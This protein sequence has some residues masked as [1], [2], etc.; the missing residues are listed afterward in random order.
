[1]NLI[2]WGALLL[3]AKWVFIGLVYTALFVVLIA[4]RREMSLRVRVERQATTVAAGRLKVIAPGTDGRLSPGELLSLQP[5]SQLGAA[6]DNDVTVQDQYVSAHHAR[7]RWD[8]ASWWVEDLGSRNGTFVNRQRCTP[9]QP[10]LLPP[11]GLLQV[12]GMAFELLE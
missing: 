7:L 11:G 1:M 3:A 4:V 2:G 10:T 5:E 6:A 12:G 9:L 8:G